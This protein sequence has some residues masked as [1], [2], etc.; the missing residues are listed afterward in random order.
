MF[1]GIG[2]LGQQPEIVEAEVGLVQRRDLEGNRTGVLST[3]RPCLRR[4]PYERFGARNKIK[5]VPAAVAEGRQGQLEG[6][7]RRTCDAPRVDALQGS[8]GVGLIDDDGSYALSANLQP[9]I[10][11]GRP[12]APVAGRKGVEIAAE[13]HAFPG[14]DLG[15]ASRQEVF[16]V[17]FLGGAAVGL[18]LSFFPSRSPTVG[19]WMPV[20]VPMSMY[21][22]TVS[23]WL[24]LGRMTRC[25]VSHCW[26]DSTWVSVAALMRPLPAFNLAP[27][28]NAG[29]SC[30]RTWSGPSRSPCACPGT[31]RCPGGRQRG[32]PA[33]PRPGRGT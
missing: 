28:R 1:E 21:R 33:R 16:N 12:A 32:R 13:R 23:I 25:R 2:V 20:A 17:G 27:P 4:R 11:H 29:G 9:D 18:G 30:S 19:S 24:A 6:V 31:C 8:A 15:G 14:P 26:A 5:P 22:G 3:A 7:L 10:I